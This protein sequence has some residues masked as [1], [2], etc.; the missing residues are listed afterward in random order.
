MYHILKLVRKL[1][2]MSLFITNRQ[3]KGSVLSEENVY[4]IQ[5]WVKK[6]QSSQ[7]IKTLGAVN[8]CYAGIYVHS[9][10]TN[11][12][13]YGNSFVLLLIRAKYI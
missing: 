8:W 9:Q 11:V 1:S 12:H 5:A 2:A 7:I 3:F 6:G 10:E 13:L 4:G